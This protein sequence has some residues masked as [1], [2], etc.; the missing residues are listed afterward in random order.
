MQ[1]L[2]VYTRFLSLPSTIRQRSGSRARV[3]SLQ[4]LRFAPFAR[5]RERAALT[6]LATSITGSAPQSSGGGRIATLRSQ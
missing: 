4:L 6:T 5:M 1:S 3:G 2:V